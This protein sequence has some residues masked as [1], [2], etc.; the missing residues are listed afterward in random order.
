MS[1]WSNINGRLT[2]H[3]SKHLSLSKLAEEVFDDY[4]ISIDTEFDGDCFYH[5]LNINYRESDH[6]ALSTFMRFK[7]LLLSCNA[8]FVLDSKISWGN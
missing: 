3:K 8:K 7:D 6:Q 5:E 1:Y 2:V 4:N